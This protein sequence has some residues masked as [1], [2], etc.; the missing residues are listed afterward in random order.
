MPHIRQLSPH[1]ANLIAAG[2]VVERPA[3]VVKE[4]LENAEGFQ[5]YFGI[6]F[7]DYIK[8]K[9]KT[10]NKISYKDIL[11]NTGNIANIL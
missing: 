8:N 4:L 5:K 3:S 11:Y 1:V 7:D 6:S 9:L 10:K 2:E